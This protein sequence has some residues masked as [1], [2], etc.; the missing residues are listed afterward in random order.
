MP[1]FA[2]AQLVENHAAAINAIYEAF[3]VDD[4]CVRLCAVQLG[5][6]EEASGGDGPAIPGMG[7]RE[8]M[9]TLT[10]TM[11]RN[12]ASMALAHGMALVLFRS[13]KNGGVGMQVLSALLPFPSG[14][15]LDRLTRVGLL[16]ILTSWFTS[17]SSSGGGG[18]GGGGGGDGGGG[19]VVRASVDP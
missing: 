18:G 7:V 8:V 10:P 12:L 4:G 9:L 6:G 11:S 13:D 3:F 5:H 16:P 14:L 15:S 17:S 1:R 2:W 19:A